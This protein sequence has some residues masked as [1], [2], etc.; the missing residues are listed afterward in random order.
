MVTI[1]S[2]VVLSPMSLFIVFFRHRIRLLM[3]FEISIF[4]P[5]FLVGR[6]L[7]PDM[8]FHAERE[9]LWYSEADVACMS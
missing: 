8:D 4:S 5:F 1:V 3:Y 9:P 2:T 7:T 6:K